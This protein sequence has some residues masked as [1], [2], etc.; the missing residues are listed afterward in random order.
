MI[1]ASRDTRYRRLLWVVS[2]L[3]ALNLNVF[4][5]ISEF[6]YRGS[7][8]VPRMMSVL[9]LT[10]WLSLANCATLVWHAVLLKRVCADPAVLEQRGSYRRAITT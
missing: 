10:V 4:Y 3:F 9:D 6:E 7:Y 1:A 2:V 8:M 5:G